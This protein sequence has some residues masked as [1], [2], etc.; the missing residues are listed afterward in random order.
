MIWLYK[1]GDGKTQDTVTL[2]GRMAEKYQIDCIGYYIM[3]I[4]NNEIPGINLRYPGTL[5]WYKK[6]PKISRDYK[7]I[8][9]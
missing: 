7:D 8:T 3:D 1:E 4:S 6:G 9:Q 2:M 5:L